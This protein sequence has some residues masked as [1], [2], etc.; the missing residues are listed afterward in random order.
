LACL[1][2]DQIHKGGV[3]VE[4]EF[5]P[6]EIPSIKAIIVNRILVTVV[7]I[8]SASIVAHPNV[9]ALIVKLQLKWLAS[10]SPSKP[11]LSIT[12]TAWNRQNRILVSYEHVTRFLLLLVVNVA[13]D[14]EHCNVPSISCL[15]SKG[16]ERVSIFGTLSRE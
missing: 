2:H 15:D 16:L 6:A 14:M 1:L 5:S 4:T 7:A 8:L 9:I 13:R 12:E 11:G 3:I 10:L